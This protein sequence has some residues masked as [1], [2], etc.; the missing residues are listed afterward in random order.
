MVTLLGIGH[1]GPVDVFDYTGSV[2]PPGTKFGTFEPK[3]FDKVVAYINRNGG[4]SFW[5]IHPAKG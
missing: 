5:T 4:S 3:E 1:D 2:Y